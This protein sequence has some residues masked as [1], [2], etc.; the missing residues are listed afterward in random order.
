MKIK[1]AEVFNRYGGEMEGWREGVVCVHRIL[2]IHRYV[3][4]SKITR[5]F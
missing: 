1:V 2:Q 3:H 4:I 5:N